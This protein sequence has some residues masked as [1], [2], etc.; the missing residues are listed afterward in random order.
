MSDIVLPV[1]ESAESIPA[2]L[3]APKPKKVKSPTLEF[4]ITAWWAMETM[5][6]NPR[7]VSRASRPVGSKLGFS[8]TGRGSWPATSFSTP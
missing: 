3:A 1:I 8:L 4:S 6:P 5:S 2:A 7:L